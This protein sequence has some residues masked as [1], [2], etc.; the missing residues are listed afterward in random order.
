MSNMKDRAVL[1]LSYFTWLC[2]MRIS[3]VGNIDLAVGDTIK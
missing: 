2:L 1:S 3:Y